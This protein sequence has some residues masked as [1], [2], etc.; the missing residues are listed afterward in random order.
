[1][2]NVEVT[3]NA[4]NKAVGYQVKRKFDK[5]V[6]F[7]KTNTR[8]RSLDFKPLKLGKGIWRFRVNDHYWGL[9]YKKPDVENTLV[10]YDVIKHP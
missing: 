3:D 5:Q 1:M 9:T 10:V 7:L 8:H 6:E 4:T 2:I